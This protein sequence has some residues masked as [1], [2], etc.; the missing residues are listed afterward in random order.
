MYNTKKERKNYTELHW[1]LQRPLMDL[2]GSEHWTV[3]GILIH[4]TDSSLLNLFIKLFLSNSVLLSFYTLF[5]SL[6][7]HTVTPNGIFVCR[8]YRACLSDALFIHSFSWM[9]R[10]VLLRLIAPTRVSKHKI[11]SFSEG[12]GF[13]EYIQPTKFSLTALTRNL[14]ALAIITLWRVASESFI[15]K[16]GPKSRAIHCP[17]IWRFVLQRVG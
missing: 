3:V 16:T 9:T 2:D 8:G 15:W 1:I 13:V 14:L 6:W 12:G 17:L 5:Y 7:L 11:D 10:S 4:L